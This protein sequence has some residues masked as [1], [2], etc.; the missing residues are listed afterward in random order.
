MKKVLTLLLFCMTVYSAHAQQDLEDVE[1]Q[2]P[3]GWTK[4]AKK[5]P[6]KTEWGVPVFVRGKEVAEPSWRR[7]QTMNDTTKVVAI[8]GTARYCTTYAD[9]KAGN[10]K[11]LQ[12]V[13]MKA[14]STSRRFWVGGNDFRIDSEDK[15]TAKLLK[16]DAL[17]VVMGD[18][19]YVN[20]RK[21]RGN[22]AKLVRG[23]ARG[24]RYDGD[25]VCF[26]NED[27]GNIQRSTF[28]G[29]QFG[30][31]GGLAA[32]SSM[33]EDLKFHLC[34]VL[35]DDG[36]NATSLTAKDIENLIISRTDRD[37]LWNWYS[38]LPKMEKTRAENIL[39]VLEELDLLRAY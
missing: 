10:W 32:A 30:L 26:L 20:C 29:A 14:N 1:I 33:S 36:K 28:L 5:K 22:K 13:E 2:L 38:A 25:K 9:F 19:L 15:E 27:Q 4:P 34:Y 23:Y 7:P 6:L 24:Y 12:D 35:K 8:K 39:V 37:D 21:L 18:L 17:F 31:I 11:Q 16:K 3:N